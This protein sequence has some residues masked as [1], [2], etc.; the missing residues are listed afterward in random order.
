LAAI[1]QN[2]GVFTNNGGTVIMTGTTAGLTLSGTGMTGAGKF[3]N[4][5]FNGVGGSWL[6]S[7]LVDIGGN[8]TI[9]SGSIIGSV[10][11][12]VS[13]NFIINGGSFTSAFAGVINVGGNWFNAG[14]FIHNGCTVNMVGIISGL[15]LS[16]NMTGA[17]KFNVL[18]FNGTG[19]FWSFGGNSADVAGNFTIINGTVVSPTTLLNITGNWSNGGTYVE[20]LSGIVNVSGTWSNIG[21]FTNN[22]GTVNLTGITTGLTLSGN[23]TAGNKFYN[24][25][26][27]G[28]GGSWSF[29]N[30]ADVGGN[31][32]ILNGIVTGPST[33]NVLLNFSI[34]G[35]SYISAT[36]GIIYVGGNWFNSGIFIHNNCTV[37]MNG[38]ATGLLLSGNMTL[39][40]N[41]R[42]YNL[43]FSGSGSWTFGVYTADIAG[44]F[45][46]TGTGSVTGSSTTL[47][48]LGNW[49]HTGTGLFIHNNGSVI[50]SGNLSTL[51]GFMITG[52]KFNNISFTGGGTYTFGSNADANGN[53]IITNGTVN[54]LAGGSYHISGNWNIAGTGVFNNT[55]NTFL[56]FVGGNWNNLGIFNA[57]AGT[58][59]MN[60]VSGGLT[61]SGNLTGSNKFYNLIFN[62]T[63][64]NWMISDNID[65]AL[66]F[67]ILAGTV[68]TIT[69]HILNVWGNWSNS[70][71]FVAG[72]TSKLYI[73]SI[74]GGNWNNVGG[75]FTASTCTVNMVGT[76]AGL[77]ISGN[78]TGG[79]KFNILNFNGVN[80][81]WTFSS[82][83][84]TDVAG[85]FTIQNGT[86]NTSASH[87]LSVQGNWTNYG[88]FNAGATSMINESASWF[89]NGI[90]NAGTGTVNMNGLVT[91]LSLN[92]NM[93][94]AT[95]GRFYNL[96]FNGVGGSWSLT[97]NIDVLAN[98]TIITG[99]VNTPAGHILNVTGNWSN[100]G[101]YNAG[102]LTFINVGGNWGNTG[103][104]SASTSSVNM[105]GTTAGLTLSGLMTS[106]GKFY[107]LTFNGLGGQ[108]S[109]GAYAA[110]V[111]NDFIITA[112][113]L[114][115]PSSTLRVAGNY[116][117]NGTFIHNNGT[118]IMN[119][120]TTGLT[121]N[122]AMTGINKFYTLTFDGIGGAW[123]FGPNAADA[124]GDFSII[125]GIVTAP[126]T[127]LQ[128][129]GNWINS[130]TFNHNN[131][132]VN[133]FGTFLQHITG[134][135]RFYNVTLDNTIGAIINND[136]T[137]DGTFTI[138]VGVINIGINNL[139]FGPLATISGVFSKTAMIIANSSGQI[140]RQMTGNGSFLFPVGD[141]A[142][143]YSPITI[144]FSGGTYNSGAYY[145][146]NVMNAKQPSN[147]NINNYLAR[148]W[149]LISANITSP[150]YE[151]TLAT[152]LPGDVVGT[153]SLLS[154][155]QYS[156]H[157]PWSKFTPVNPAAHS[158]ATA[159][160]KSDTSY[161]TGITTQ[162]PIVNSS[163]NSSICVGDSS[164]IST[165]GVT[166]DPVVSYSWAPVAGLGVTTG[167]TITAT[168]ALTTVYTVTITDAN[169][170]T[171]ISTT[172]ITVDSF[173]AVYKVTGGGDFCNGGTGVVVGLS[174]SGASSISYQLY[175]DTTAVGSSK[176]G[177]ASSL[178]F[179]LQTIP[180]IY[181]V[182]ATDI[183]A[184]CKTVMPDSTIVTVTPLVTPSINIAAALFD[185]VCAGST[186]T[187]NAK[188]TNQGTGPYY[189]WK[190]N[191]IVKGTD[192][193]GFS[194]VPTDGDVVVVTLL[195]NAYCAVIPAIATDEITMNVGKI[196][197]P[198]V[199]INASP[200]NVIAKGQDVRFAASATNAGPN[201][202]YQWYNNGAII[203]GA[204]TAFYSG[205]DFN[206]LDSVTCIVLGSGVCGMPSF[207]SIIMHVSTT[208]INKIVNN[209]DALALLP[210]P[211]T[212]TFTINLS[213]ATDVQA[214][215][216]ITNILGEK[217]KEI[218][219][220][221][222]TPAQINMTAPAGI[223]FVIAITE[224]ERYTSK[225]I[226]K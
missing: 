96:T 214:N 173:P 61:V 221:T 192:S 145:G 65:M 81:S 11:F 1:G 66:N 33:F 28:S 169:G 47:N 170:F 113:K 159:T 218:T 200:G 157:L 56:L 44:N 220:A 120:T 78:M 135:T 165:S 140:R 88:T 74:V 79:S 103:A 80:G 13:G 153:E 55:F 189:Q 151:A 14:I 41:G 175:N 67:T 48:I 208:G 93:T 97:A 222:N 59:T 57:G 22:G 20:G 25:T 110:D 217:V 98:F 7:N 107:N 27:N 137:I 195:S 37:T 158:F 90:F 62:G 131:G 184:G 91:G 29:L 194:Y 86:V 126:S 143:N 9:I 128:V 213:S 99:V 183:S 105:I 101:T 161:F 178:D 160:V 191:N 147:A 89:N 49:T 152:Y 87:I 136:E 188:P 156:G 71:I 123:S 16:G 139:V 181:R 118:L 30:L 205:A 198:A 6:F 52:S 8:F 42:F 109:F 223:Y 15:T 85:T 210:N 117:N 92:G 34:N 51:S 18:I 114:T 166:G 171:G 226:L 172:T 23:M 53:F 204:T 111:A 179:G 75:I 209:I 190:V 21:I 84:N 58:V 95:N 60:G 141:N 133:L 176:T 4:L 132:L 138:V 43:I 82:G 154:G 77:T 24:L 134:V 180:G 12:N 69:N 149:S 144:N 94:L 206:N 32:T 121:L 106:A 122:G 70:G 83:D 63:G 182:V 17:N 155:G 125:N 187:F 164:V 5:T 142:L 146:I 19:G 193:T 168:P 36:S 38:T 3:F 177:K 215:I 129:A 115:A 76:I 68:T 26:F 40:T 162:A 31:F 185:T 203:P 73:G 212:G 72:A 202:T 225:M 186:A 116:T 224:H 124:G 130:G 45:S 104:F 196:F 2:N 148:Y 197:I 174:G 211:N 54:P 163:L 100:S 167:M 119:G 10:V 199:T 127:I 112:G 39:G 50:F 46:I 102:T 108:W 216:I 207:N 64:G 150:A 201:P 219:V 35:G